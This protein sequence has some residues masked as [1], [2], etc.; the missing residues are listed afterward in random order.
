[1]FT[2]A[3]P[4]S[5]G[6]GSFPSRGRGNR[7]RGG[8]NFSAG[9]GNDNPNYYKKFFTHCHKGG[10]TKDESFELHGYPSH[11][12]FKKIPTDSVIHNVSSG[13]VVEETSSNSI[14]D[15]K[16]ET[17]E[18]KVIFT[19]EQQLCLLDLLQPASQH[20]PHQL[21]LNP[22]PSSGIF[23]SI[24]FYWLLDTSATDHV[25]FSLQFFYTY[26]RIKPIIVHLPNCQ[27]VEAHISGTVIFSP[28]FYLTNV[29]FIA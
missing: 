3:P 4:T 24:Q 6:R 20:S 1:L 9:R 28:Y 7:G 19:K 5:T 11:W 22:P 27:T 18:D 10:H 23:V 13:A 8:R 14:L 29:L 15:R 25:C 12:N 16:D 26:K 21:N 2:N 17:V